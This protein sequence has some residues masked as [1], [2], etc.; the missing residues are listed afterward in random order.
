EER[1]FS[2]SVY[3][4]LSGE[5]SEIDEVF[6]VGDEYEFNLNHFKTSND[7]NVKQMSELIE[8]LRGT[9]EFLMNV[10][11]IKENDLIGN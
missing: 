8:K 7:I 2:S 5:L 4:L 1:L 6:E 3:L 9:V 10:N 11:N